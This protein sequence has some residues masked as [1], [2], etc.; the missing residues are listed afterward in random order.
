MVL[1]ICL[2]FKFVIIHWKISNVNSRYN[3]CLLII[4]LYNYDL[5]RFIIQFKEEGIKL[6]NP[7]LH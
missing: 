7:H 1:I 3:V 2:V 4:I 5:V 6:N